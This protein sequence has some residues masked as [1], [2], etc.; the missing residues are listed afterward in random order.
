MRP[1]IR[2][3]N[4]SKLYSIGERTELF[5]SLGETLANGFRR[6]FSGAIRSTEPAERQTIWAL[7]DVSFDVFPG[8]IIGVI[9]SNGAGKSTLLKILSRIT[10]PT[11]GQVDIYGRVGSLLE[12][13]TGFHAELTGRENIYLNGTIL[14]MKRREIERKFDEIVAFSEIEKFI[15]TPVKHYS[16]GMYMR[17][18]FAV[19]AHLD[20]EILIV[21]EVLA[22]GDFA[23]QKKCI[24]KMSS[25]A[26]E[27]RT[28]LF[29]SHNMLALRSLCQKAVWLDKGTL[30]EQGDINRTVTSYLQQH[31]QTTYE[32]LW[33]LGN[34]GVIG[35]TTRIAAARLVPDL[36]T[37]VDKITVKVPLRFEFDLVHNSPDSL[38]QVSFVLYNVEGVCILNAR[39]TPKRYPAGPLRLNCHLN[40][41]LLNDDSYSVRI[42]LIKDINT[43]LFDEYNVLRFDVHDVER[44]EAWYGKWI[45]VVRPDLR[46]AEAP[47][48]TSSTFQCVS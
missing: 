8:E 18:A 29:V 34:D 28:V 12:V 10:D 2:V 22:V 6:L 48:L 45:G 14:G 16:S 23:F 13:G 32:K 9:G 27:G 42:V 26:Q 30:V 38:L 35:T 11:S 24:G 1:I 40:A 31:H 21:D 46:W 47:S 33:P 43:S 19:A 37:P 4:L 39:S 41:D 3:S 25:V 20:P 17:L 7:R 44:E 36:D 15:D 5:P